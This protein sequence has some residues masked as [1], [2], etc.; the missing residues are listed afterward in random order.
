MTI[1]KSAV[2]PLV[3]KIVQSDDRFSR[4]ALITTKLGA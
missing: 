2:L 3:P 4:I 1:N